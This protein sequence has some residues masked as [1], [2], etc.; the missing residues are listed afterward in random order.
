MQIYTKKEADCKFS[1]T[2]SAK[3]LPCVLKE[4]FQI[5]VGNGSTKTLFEAL[6]EDLEVFVRDFLSG[7]LIE[8]LMDFLCAHTLP[9]ISRL[10]YVIISRSW[11]G[12]G[13]EMDLPR[14]GL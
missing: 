5:F 8:R 12:I 6:H 3:S 13:T 10:R 11:T 7:S 1:A 2:F 4:G 14:T 9:T